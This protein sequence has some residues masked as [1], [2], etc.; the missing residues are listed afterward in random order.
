MEIKKDKL[1]KMTKKELSD[2]VIMLLSEVKELKGVISNNKGSNEKPYL[3]VSVLNINGSDCTIKVNYSIDDISEVISCPQ[4]SHMA[5][6]K[7]KK[8]L[9][10]DIIFNLK[11]YEGELL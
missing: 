7:A 8:I 1:A 2:A 11:K 10:E 9:T 4:G 6:F 3:A 5:D